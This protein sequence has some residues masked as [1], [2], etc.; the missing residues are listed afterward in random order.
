MHDTMLATAS[1]TIAAPPAT[2][3][4]ALVSPEAIKQYM[5]GTE[6]TSK[7][8]EGAPIVWTGEFQGKLY[9]DK[10]EILRM[11]EGRLLQYTHYS[12]VSGDVD[13]P[14]NYHTVT[15]ELSEDSA[16]TRVAVTQDNNANED[17]RT[18]SE[19]TWKGILDALKDYL[20]R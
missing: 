20:E 18:R 12:N 1:V 2:V 4:K 16:G 19:Q 7:W 10:G 5:F 8:K 6:V 15:M 13:T 9:E 17:D 11:D 14:E 3:W